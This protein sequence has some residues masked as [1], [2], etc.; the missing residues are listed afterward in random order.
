MLGYI[1]LFILKLFAI[2]CMYKGLHHKD[3][4]IRLKLKT[5]DYFLIFDKNIF[6]CKNR[7]NIKLM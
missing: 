3:S 1:H 2:E 4:F 6:F 7:G 5:R